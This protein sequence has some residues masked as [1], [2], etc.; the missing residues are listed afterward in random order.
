MPW[1]RV[2]GA[3]G[4]GEESFIID[5][6]GVKNQ[7]DASTGSLGLRIPPDILTEASLVTNGFS[8]RYGQALSGMIN[9]VTKDGG[10]RWA[11]RA[12]YETDRPSAS[13]SI[14]GSTAW[15]SR[16]TAPW[17]APSRRWL[18]ST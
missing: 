5:G 6:L 8:A 9:V 1:A 3:G 11:G 17:P 13:R 10:K 4:W 12:A 7:L 15:C 14:W 2:T 16:R 18:P